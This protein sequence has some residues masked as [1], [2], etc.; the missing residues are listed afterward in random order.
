MSTRFWTRFWMWLAWK[1][2]RPLVYCCTIRLMAHASTGQY[3]KQVVPDLKVVEA[4]SR[5]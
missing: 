4:L 2:P 1:M 5:W 3:S